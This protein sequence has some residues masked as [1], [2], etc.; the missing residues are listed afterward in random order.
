MPK[1]DPATYANARTFGTPER[2]SPRTCLGS[3]GRLRVVGEERSVSRNPALSRLRFLPWLSASSF[4]AISI[5]TSQRIE[6]SFA[7]PRAGYQRSRNCWRTISMRISPGSRLQNGELLS[8]ES[9]A[10]HARSQSAPR[11][12]IR[13][14]G[15]TSIGTSDRCMDGRSIGPKARRARFSYRLSAARPLETRS[16]Y[17]GVVRHGF[18]HGLVAIP[19]N[20]GPVSPA[21]RG[22]LGAVFVGASGMAPLPRARRECADQPRWRNSGAGTPECPSSRFPVYM[23][24][25]PERCPLG[26]TAEPVRAP[27][28]RWGRSSALHGRSRLQRRLRTEGAA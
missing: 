27:S 22:R 4:P 25:T 13:K 1:I 17:Q 23:T 6:I 5:S 8:C 9:G 20:D 16:A 24:G 10:L 7:S 21:E 28:S 14:R 3:S 12:A 15:R 11:R 18:A 26:A 2:R 19:P